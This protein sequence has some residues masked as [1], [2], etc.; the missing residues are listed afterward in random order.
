MNNETPTL[1]ILWRQIAQ[2]L[3][4]TAG[5]E[6]NTVAKYLLCDMLDMSQ[7]ELI[8]HSAD[9]VTAEMRSRALDS[10]RRLA[11]GE[12][13]QYVTGKAYFCDLVF[14]VAP[15]VLI[16]R[17]ETA[18]LVDIVVNEYFNQKVRILDIGTGSGCIAIALKHKL[19]QASV[20]A[21][22]VSPEALAI[23]RAN[24]ERISTEV[25]FA[26]YDI[27]LS[28]NDLGKFDVIVSNPPYVTESERGAMERNVLDYEPATALFVPDADPLRFY[29]A[30]ADRARHGLLANG[31]KLY[32]EINERFGAEMRQML[33]DKGFNNVKILTDMYGKERFAEARF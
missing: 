15:G 28:D 20:T 23:A 33:E 22:D 19:P 3:T 4:E 21:I 26:E 17:P 30:I 14:G 18:E 10:A 5:S 29:R 27:L 32:F 7:T 1:Q 8:V 31:G 9:A 11:D 13:L 12:P 25:H 6:A 2:M 24:A 16:P